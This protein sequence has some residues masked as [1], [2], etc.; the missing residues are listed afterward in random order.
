MVVDISSRG[1][2]LTWVEPHDNNAPISRYEVTFM[3]TQCDTEERDG[4]VSSTVEM[5]TITG[6]YPGVN[7]TF[8]VTAVNEIGPSLPSA[9]LTVTTEE[10]GKLL[11]TCH[12][13]SH[14]SYPI[15]SSF[16]SS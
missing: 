6:L 2:T 3:Q 15:C 9:P 11:N 4:E 8:T 7:Y 10:E 14:I 1:L 5:T 16:Q 12:V 13:L